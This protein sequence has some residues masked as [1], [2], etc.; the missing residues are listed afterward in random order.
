MRRRALWRWCERSF[1][2]G[3]NLGNTYRLRHGNSI[4]LE[5]V[6]CG[7]L[8]LRRSAVRG[9]AVPDMVFDV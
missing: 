5:L 2:G 8:E 1:G 7:L 3:L 4:V 6:E 9:I